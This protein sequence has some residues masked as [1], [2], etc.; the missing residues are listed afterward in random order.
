MEQIRTIIINGKEYAITGESAY[1]VAVR[2]GFEGTEEEWLTSLTNE[3]EEKAAV[4]LEA[5]EQALQYLETET[6]NARA[7][8][9]AAEAEAVEHIEAMAEE[10]LNVVQSTGDSETAVMSQK[11]TTEAING[12]YAD[13]MIEMTGENR[14]DSN[15]DE[16][17]T[18][19]QWYYSYN[20][21]GKA[22]SKHNTAGYT[23]LT[24][25]VNGDA[26]FTFSTIDKSVKFYGIY[27]VDENNLTLSETQ[28]ALT[29]LDGYTVTIPSAAKYVCVTVYTVKQTLLD[30]IMCATGEE[31]KDF[32]PYTPPYLRLK[33]C[34][35]DSGDDVV[36]TATLKTPSQY[37]LV[38]GDTFE[39]FYKGVINAVNTDLFNIEIECAKGYPFKKR[40]VF[41][42]SAENIGTVPMTIRLYDMHHKLLDVKTLSLVVKAKAAS[43]TT[44]KTV[45]YITDSLGANGYVPEEFN[46]R[47][48]GNGGAP[49]ADNMENISFIGSCESL[50]S[51]VKYEGYGGWTFSSYNGAAKSNAY[52]WVTASHNKTLDDQHSTYKDSNNVVWKLETIETDRIKLIRVSGS[53]VLPES[54]TLTW[55]SGG[56]NRG[57][58]V[59]TA[60]EQASGNPFWNDSA[61]KVDFAN[62][63][64][65][66]GKAALDYVYVLL[67]WNG[68]GLS[69]ESI[70]TQTKTFIDNVLSAYPNCKIVL[71]GLQV[72]S[73]EGVALNYGASGAYSNYYNLL[74]YVWGLNDLYTEIATEYDTVSFVNISGQ[75][76]TENNMMSGSRAVNVRNETTETYQTN[77]VHPA[78]SGYYQIA[79]ACYRDFIHKIQE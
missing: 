27:T 65:K 55:A 69:N 68:F 32:E 72:P 78:Q 18:I 25:P 40:F 39:L 2:N 46:R 76:D 17:R 57:A 24:I 16:M 26:A 43:P 47:L 41:T 74:N 54:G 60:S 9:D 33:N 73:Q 49:A 79:D 11:A 48:V 20:G 62:Y 44:E 36:Q 66:Q 4:A 3:V 7:N 38:V 58:I 59:Y 29:I 28:G 71:L 22:L 50:V 75:F 37:E 61:A 21:M 52:M 42:P 45:L 53:G 56:V 5:A 35:L 30:G 8:I 64:A 77:G 1:E 70:K 12:K 14:F 51:K 10:V 6:A 15:S 63:V 19:G 23:A 13:Y 34:K 67:G 31:A